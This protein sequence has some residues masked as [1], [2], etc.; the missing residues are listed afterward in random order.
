MEKVKI[1][2]GDITK[3]DVDAIVNAANESLLGG[4]GVDGAIHHAAGKELLDECRTLNGCKT[5]K[6][7]ITKG[8]NLPAK[9]I[10][11]TVGPVYRG[12]NHGEPEL[13]RSCYQES[14]ALAVSNNIKTIAYPCI[15]TGIFGY[16]FRDACVTALRAI[17]DFLQEEKSISKVFMVCFSDVD[18]KCYESVLKD[19]Q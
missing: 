17:E 12:G 2:Q 9:Y 5:G 14:L 10:I 13:L 19:F 7:K 6:A 8:Y 3:L 11:H 4:V 18:F 16:P 1:I 15:S